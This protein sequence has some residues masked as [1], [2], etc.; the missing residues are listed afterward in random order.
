MFGKGWLGL[1]SC[2]CCSACDIL[3]CQPFDLA[4]FLLCRSVFRLP[5]PS[6]LKFIQLVG[7]RSS[8]LAHLPPPKSN[9]EC[10]VEFCS[11]S[12]SVVNHA[13]ASGLKLRTRGLGCLKPA[14]EKMADG[15]ALC[16][17]GR[18]LP[19]IFELFDLISWESEISSPSDTGLNTYL[20]VGSTIILCCFGLSCFIVRSVFRVSSSDICVQSMCV[21]EKQSD[22]N[23]EWVLWAALNATNRKQTIHG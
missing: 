7:N 2:A 20:E 19:E 8:F 21:N 23:W 6:A 12:I 11:S 14:N 17:T 4:F 13:Y 1:L 18:L 10:G 22:R 15:Q 5:N 16:I 3:N 9:E